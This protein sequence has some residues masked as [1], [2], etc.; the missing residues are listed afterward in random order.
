MSTTT[1][2][3]NIIVKFGGFTNGMTIQAVMER[4]KHIADFYDPIRK[5]IYAFTWDGDPFKRKGST[6]DEARGTP[7]CFTHALEFLKNHF[8]EIPWIAAKRIDQLDSLPTFT[9]LSMV[10]WKWVVKVYL[11]RSMSWRK[12]QMRTPK[13]CRLVVSMS[14]QHQQTFTGPSSVLKTYSGTSKGASKFIT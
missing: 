7:A 8:P 6:L 4:A 2:Q 9:L 11:V 5:Q 12:W 3:K 1:L 14:S 10:A 13:S